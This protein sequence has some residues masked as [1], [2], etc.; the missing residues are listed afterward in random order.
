ML[1][2]LIFD[3]DG[4]LADTE[5]VHLEAFNHAFRQEGLDWHWST[6]QYTQLLDISGGKERML[7]HWRTVDPD[8]KEVDAGALTDTI[9]RLHEIKTAYYENAVNSGAVTLRPGVLALMNEARGQGLQLAIA[10]TTSPVNIAAL[11][12]S[13]IGLDWRSH[14]L[15]VGDASNAP[16]K[17]PHPQVYLKVLADMGMSAPECVAFE[18]SSNGLRA[19]TAAGL[20][21]VITPNSFTAHHDFKGALRVVPDLSQV[22]VARLR[23]WHNR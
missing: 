2:A 3:V 20:D 12:R 13:A 1:N 19:A 10:T 22:N 15:A 18:D 5:S 4:T 6:E 7:H 11:M 21:T 16:I 9:N 17:K 14:F 8:M 23:E